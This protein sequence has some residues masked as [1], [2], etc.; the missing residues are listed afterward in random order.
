M[1][2]WKTETSQ[3]KSKIK[4]ILKIICNLIAKAQGTYYGEK[5]V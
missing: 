3:K 1:E 2:D 5:S 4:L